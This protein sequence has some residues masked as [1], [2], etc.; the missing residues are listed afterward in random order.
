MTNF[1]GYPGVSALLNIK[2]K[3]FVSYHH[4][5]DRAWY[6]AFARH[7]A[8]TY[9]VIDDNS[10]ERAIDSDDVEYVMRRIRENYVTGSSCTIVLCGA[11]TRWRKFVDWEIT[12]TLDKEHGLIGVKLPTNPIVNNGCA[13]PDRLQDNIDSGYAVWSLWETITGNAAVL[14]GLIEEANAKNK[15]LIRNWRE[16][17]QR[18]G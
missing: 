6:D 7:F 3:V 12:A 15:G 13:K 5:G 8:E 9:D 17:R 10:V 16:R 11:E 14:P 18:N 2:R 1:F 4:G